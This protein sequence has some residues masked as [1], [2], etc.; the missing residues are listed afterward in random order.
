MFLNLF[1]HVY[2]LQCRAGAGWRQPVAAK[3]SC[4]H[5]SSA[6]WL[7]ALEK[8]MLIRFNWLMLSVFD[9]MDFNT[10]LTHRCL[11]FQVFIFLHRQF[12]FSLF[13]KYL[14]CKYTQ[15]RHDGDLWNGTLWSA[16]CGVRIGAQTMRWWYFKSM[17][18]NTMSIFEKV[19]YTVTFTI[20]KAPNRRP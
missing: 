9:I 15:M 19:H 18:T 4:K 20:Y 12:S 17:S 1:I 7:W 8:N 16:V 10:F 2:V 5:R 3:H 6:S 13:T 11:C 14:K